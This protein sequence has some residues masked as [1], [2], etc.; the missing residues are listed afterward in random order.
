[1]DTD[2]E[3]LFSESQQ[4]R[5]GWIWLILLGINGLF[6]FAIF[7]QII[8]GQPF[9]NNPMSNTGL[10]VGMALSI[11][12]TIIM[13]N[14]RLDTLIK[15]DGIYVRFFPFH[16]R[17]KKYPW[18]SLT[19]SF[20]KEYSPITEYG[21]WGLRYGFFGKGKAFSISG[22]KGLQLEDKDNKKLLIGTQ[23]PKELMEALNLVGQLKK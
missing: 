3:I 22:N 5:Q 12:F 20:V 10:L 17:F 14:F 21:G 18:E 13:A 7:R 4:I 23:K 19:K 11:L 2:K 6:I 9:G 8:G 1:M 16:L 15:K